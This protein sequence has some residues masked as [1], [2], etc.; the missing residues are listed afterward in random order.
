MRAFYCNLQTRI[1]SKSA[2]TLAFSS[3]S[4]GLGLKVINADCL[5]NKLIST[6]HKIINSLFILI[7]SLCQNCKMCNCPCMLAIVHLHTRP[8][9]PSIFIRWSQMVRILCSLYHHQRNTTAPQNLWANVTN[10]TDWDSIKCTKF[11]DS[12]NCMLS[13]LS[14][15]FVHISFSS[16]RDKRLNLC[17]PWASM[18][19]INFWIKNNRYM[20]ASI[21]IATNACPP[22]SCWYFVTMCVVY[23]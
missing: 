5:T 1:T 7:G 23:A 12:Y 17:L 19:C 20:H 10:I 18:T 16:S 21:P 4:S 11:I 6:L 9:N 13:P 2:W 14:M 15:A 3:V 22:G 8:R